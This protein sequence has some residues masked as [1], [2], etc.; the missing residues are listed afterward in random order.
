MSNK[1]EHTEG[2]IWD[3]QTFDRGQEHLAALRDGEECILSPRYNSYGGTWI[4]VDDDHAH[5]IAAAPELLTEGEQSALTLREAAKVFSGT[6]MSGMAD[7]MDAQ[8]ENQEVACKSARG[9][10]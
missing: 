3:K 5:L 6:D 2:W 4:A 8:A 10:S 1:T 9:T 7:I